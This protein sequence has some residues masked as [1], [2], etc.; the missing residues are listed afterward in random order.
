M[1]IF[2]SYRSESNGGDFASP[3]NFPDKPS[4]KKTHD[5]L[6]Q[7][8]H[9]LRAPLNNIQ[10]WVHVLESQISSNDTPLVHRA[11]EGIKLGVQQQ[12]KIIEAMLDSK[13]GM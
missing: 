4:E 8:S 5:V 7:V 3:L 13:K 10:S 12:V 11:L 2:L 6:R 1:K 9:D